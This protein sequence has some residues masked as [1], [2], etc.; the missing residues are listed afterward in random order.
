M[1][2][3]ISRWVCVCDQLSESNSRISHSGCAGY[4]DAPDTVNMAA[5]APDAVGMIGSSRE[6][7][8]ANVEWQISQSFPAGDTWN[9]QGFEDSRSDAAYMLEILERD[10][11]ENPG[12]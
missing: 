8:I 9:Y 6:E 1:P 4:V 7:Q 11:F 3:A 2:S 10:S 12:L 5:C